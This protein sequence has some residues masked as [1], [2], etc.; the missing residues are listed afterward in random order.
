MRTFSENISFSLPDELAQIYEVI[1]CLKYTEQTATY[2]LRE[3]QSDWL[4]LLKTAND[5]VFAELLTNEKNILRYIRQQDSPLAA[6]FPTPVYL[7][8]YPENNMTYYVRTYIEGKTLEELCETSYKKPGLSPTRALDYILALTELLQFLHS[9]NPPLIHRD[10]KPQNVVIDA[11]GG[12]HF[13]DL[14]ISRFYQVT[15]HSDTFIMGTK[16]TA[17]PEQFGYQQTDTR[18]D[19]YSMGILLLYCVTGEYKVSDQNLTELPENLQYIIQK[20]TM[21]DPD[22]RYQNA[23]ELL[24]DLLQARYPDMAYPIHSRARR[25]TR[26]Y[27]AAIGALLAANLILTSLLFFTKTG[28]FTPAPSGSP[29]QDGTAASEPQTASGSEY[30]FQEPLIE[31]AIRKQLNISEGPIKESDLLKVTELHIFGLQIYSDDSEIWFR[32]EFPWIFDDATRETGLYL[33]QGPISSLAD[34]THMPNLKVL[35]LYGQQITDVSALKDMELEELG[36]GYNPLTDLEPLTGNSSIRYLNLAALDITDISVLS[37]L[38]SLVS[39]NISSTGVE[40]IEGLEHCPIQALNIYQTGLK[41]YGQLCALPHLRELSLYTITP[42][43][44][45][46]L[47]GLPLTDIEFCYSSGLTL[48]DFSVFPQLTD[49]EFNGNHNAKLTLDQ[50]ELPKLQKLDLKE[51]TV[52]DFSG[53]SSLTSLTELGIYSTVCESYDGLDQIAN[54]RTLI[55]TAEQYEDIQNQYPN[56][57]YIYLY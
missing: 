15:K 39:L 17:P 47:A 12:C 33:Q 5:P 31:E 48:E 40:S 20:A 56:Q 54:L 6:S 35:S 53:L 4:Y 49:L 30:S 18:S 23:G 32:G 28:R 38:P 46:H 16:L 41:D 3:K 2:L 1:S 37:T 34:I 27:R 57:S 44:I 13:I 22:K 9:L 45:Q 19:L 8:T 10:I 50:P 26:I 36:L 21:F 43:I 52:S 14:G 51:V 42:E 29:V 24:P 55:C 7:K 25:R 11:E